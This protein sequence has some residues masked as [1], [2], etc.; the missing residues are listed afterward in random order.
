MTLFSAF[1]LPNFPELMKKLNSFDLRRAYACTV[2]LA[3][4]RLLASCSSQQ[5]YNAGQAWQ[6]NQC[7]KMEDAAERNRC[8][9]STKTS[10]DDYRREAEAAKK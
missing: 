4:C 10:Y 1:S 6:Q 2:L 3:A 8:M 5:L 7:V 9:A